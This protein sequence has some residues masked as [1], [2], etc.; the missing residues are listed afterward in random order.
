MVIEHLTDPKGTLLALKR[1]LIPPGLL[2]I[3]VPNLRHFRERLRTG[4]TMDDSHLFYF[5]RRSLTNLLDTCGFDVL[6]VSEG[7]RPF[8]AFGDRARR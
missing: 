7:L 2:L 3:E 5:S 1:H 4:A 8:R 6:H